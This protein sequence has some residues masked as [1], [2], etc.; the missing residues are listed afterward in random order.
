M[1]VLTIRVIAA[2]PV[3]RNALV[4]QIERSG[5]VAV[6][7]V[8]EP[9]LDGAGLHDVVVTTVSDC[10]PEECLAMSGRGASVLILTPVPRPREAE[11]YAASGAVAYLPMRVDGSDLIDTI[12]GIVSHH[13]G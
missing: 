4:R 13:A 7:T 9:V 5:R 2:D 11:A 8:A 6:T 12:S 10:P 1:G 3:L